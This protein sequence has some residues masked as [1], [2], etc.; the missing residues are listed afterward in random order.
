METSRDASVQLPSLVVAPQRP[1]SKKRT[2]ITPKDSKDSKEPVGSV[3]SPTKKQKINTVSQ[4]EKLPA[5]DNGIVI[6]QAVERTTEPIFLNLPDDLPLPEFMKYI[7]FLSPDDEKWA[8]MPLLHMEEMFSFVFRRIDRESE[9]C[10]EIYKESDFQFKEECEKFLKYLKER[11]DFTKKCPYQM[12]GAF[13]DNV[14]AFYI[15]T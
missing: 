1:P 15:E 12:A 14:E 10:R 9:I 13:I 7:K 11:P 3:D 5:D 4:F 2:Q 6:I 8:P